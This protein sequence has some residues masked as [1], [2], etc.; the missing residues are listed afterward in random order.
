MDAAY[1]VALK[2]TLQEEGGYSNNPE[3]PGGATMKGVTQAVY[4][5]YRQ[6]KNLD[7]QDVRD[8]SD[9]EVSDIYYNEY[10]LPSHCDDL[11]IKLSICQFDTAVNTGIEESIKIL[12]RAIDVKDDGIFGPHTKAAANQPPEDALVDEYIDARR[13]FYTSLAQ[14]KPHL[15]EFLHGWLKRCD[16]LKEM[17]DGLSSD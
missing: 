9:E 8:I 5:K 1:T 16:Q 6:S 7:T 4:D 3:D 15:A 17:L 11:P 14:E 2:F 10:W 12:Q 13:D